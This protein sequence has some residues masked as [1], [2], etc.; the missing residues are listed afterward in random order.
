MSLKTTAAPCVLLIATL[1]TPLLA[2]QA[3]AQSSS[4]QATAVDEIIVTGTKTGD[5]GARSGIPLSRMPQSVQVMDDETIL[6]RG[7]RSIEDALRAVPSATVAGSRIGTG[8]SNTLRVRGFAAQIMRNGMRQR[9]YEGVDSSALSNVE[10]VEVLKGPSGVLYGQSGVG[11]I[12]SIITKQPTDAFK[13]SAALTLGSDDRRMATFDLGGPVTETLGVRLTGE[14]ERSDSFADLI[15]L[16]RE[17]IALTLAWRPTDRISAR[18]M[19][20]YLNRRTVN[21]PGLPTVGTVISNGVA[22]IDRSTFLGEPGYNRQENDAPL[23]QGWADI[24]L[25]DTWT[26]TP[27]L[28]YS[29]FN[30]AARSTTLLAPVAGQP[31]LIQRVGRNAG[32]HDEFYL[33]QLD[34]AGRVTALGVQ[35]QLLLGAEYSAE[36]VNFRTEDNVPCGVGPIDALNPVYGCRAPTSNFGFLSE[37]YLDGYA[38]YAQGQIA[39]TPAWNV[40]LGL[41]HSEFQND[42]AFI[43]AFFT[44]TNTADL[45]NTTWQVGTTYALGNGVS[46]FGGYNT[47]Y[48]L[49]WVI[50]ARRRD[51]APFQPETSDQAEAGLRVAREAWRASLSAFQ[52]HRNEVAT[53]DPADLGFQ[54]QDGQFRVR[55]VEAEGEW[56]P[57]PNLWLQGGYAW[58][59]G[60]VSETTD[61]ALQGAR[62]A[63]TPEHSATL[64][65]R[66]TAGPVEWRAAAN[67]VGARK[68]INGGAVTL[69]D[70]T[71]VDLGAGVG[72]GAWRVD[73]AVTNV[74]DETFYYS[75]NLFVYSIGTEDS[76][77]TGDP[78]TF[79]VRLTRRFVG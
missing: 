40:I 41:R 11:G 36:R 76:V 57:I 29:E 71:T 12:V 16:D 18:L 42:N 39:L 50:G 13:G 28:Q 61:P 15:G 34:L 26:L 8:T 35:H 49:E 52:I 20:E 59:D 10:R 25:S 74:F 7:A 62:L 77:L 65:A 32:E 56:L 53:P 60:E 1:A 37:A 45:S 79:S 24:R 51:G 2:T 33:V 66:W 38:L 19:A 4:S 27:R 64:S 21:N 44:S 46:L 48:D 17:N 55:G 68:M 70:Y 30:N 9:F 72:F 47:G 67:Y 6:A 31:T 69:P 75:D 63:E 14:I 23:I 78:R 54:V 43:T 3:L 73:A 22:P 58:L 5:F